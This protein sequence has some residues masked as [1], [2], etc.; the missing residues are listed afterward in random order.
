[1]HVLAGFV[2]ALI[3]RIGLQWVFGKVWSNVL[4]FSWL[5]IFFSLAFNKSVPRFPSAF[6]QEAG[7]GMGGLM[8][9]GSIV[10]PMIGAKLGIQSA[11][12]SGAKAWIGSLL[13]GFM[14]LALLAIWFLAAS[15]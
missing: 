5:G 9:L 1:M 6:F 4:V 7:C 10:L 13:I 8:L 15:N 14:L 11:T 12:N 3:L 2:V